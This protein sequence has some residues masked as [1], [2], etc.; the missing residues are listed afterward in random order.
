MKNRLAILVY[1]LLFIVVLGVCFVRFHNNLKETKKTP[2]I[3]IVGV[4]E[5]V[6]NPLQFR[7]FI[8]VVGEVIKVNAAK[9]M[10]LLGCQDTCIIM[11]VRYKGQMPKLGDRITVFG[12]IKQ[13]KEKYIFEATEVK[14]N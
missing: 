11:P 4:D 9:G 1:S 7:G 13:E 6:S 5:I 12:E 10:F 2:D 8:G 3:K 14:L